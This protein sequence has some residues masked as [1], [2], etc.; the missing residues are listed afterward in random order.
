MSEPPKQ[1]VDVSLVDDFYL[2]IIQNCK[3][4]LRLK[5]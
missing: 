4:Y 3:L 1:A 2:E 5:I